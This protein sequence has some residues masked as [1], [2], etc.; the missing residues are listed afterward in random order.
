MS[1]KR[2][3]LSSGNK[4]YRIDISVEIGDIEGTSIKEARSKKAR[5]CYVGTQV[6]QM[7]QI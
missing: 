6:S 7:W 3:P 4:M 1:R 5:R 2:S